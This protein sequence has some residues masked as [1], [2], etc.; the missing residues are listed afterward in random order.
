MG[1]GGKGGILVLYIFMRL[2]KF[3]YVVNGEGREGG[4]PR[5]VCLMCIYDANKIKIRSKWGG[6]GSSYCMFDVNL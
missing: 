2:I 4:D 1:R 3:K 5:T 6:G